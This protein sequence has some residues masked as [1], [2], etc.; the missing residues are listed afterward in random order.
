MR[1][2]T[3]RWIRDHGFSG[4]RTI[5]ALRES[6]LAE[7][8]QSRGVYLILRS[9]VTTPRFL[10]ISPAGRL[11]GR[12]PSICPSELR[13]RWV[14]PSPVLYIGKAG[15]ST[16]NSTLRSRLKT[17]LQHGAGRKAPHWGGRAIWQL[18]ESEHLILAWCIV[19][20]E[21]PREVE[22]RLLQAFQDEFGCRPFANRTG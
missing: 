21:E 20:S 1:F 17:Y 16:N 14:P 19:T 11:K 15:S 9:T 13:T 10:S 5:A 18:R 3:T 12:D 4:F 2:R 7:V 6:R 8:P 22:K